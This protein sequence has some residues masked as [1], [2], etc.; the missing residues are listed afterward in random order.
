MKR[1][2]QITKLDPKFVNQKLQEFFKEDEISEDITTN[3]IQQ[4]NKIVEACFIAK[5]SMIF[6]GKEIII[7]GLQEECKLITI[8]QDGERA[9]NGEIIARL[10]GPVDVI[11]KKERVILNLLQR[12]SGIASTTKKLKNKLQKHGIQLLDTRKTTPGLRQFEKFAVNVGGGTNHRLSLKDAAMIKD[13]HLIG[14]SSLSKTVESVV[15]QNPGK[16]VEVEVD[17]KE[18]LKEALETRATS[19]LLDNF[20]PESLPETINYIRSHKKGLGV[21][22]ELSGGIN[23]SNIDQYNIKG[24][25]GISVGALT[26]NITSKDISLDLK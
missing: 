13:N 11:L 7:Q 22:I 1:H 8:K 17:T 4:E 18:Q 9:E 20:S 21:Y 6:A 16:D 5:E 26:H 3:T 10:E 14:S 24:V 25:D 12:L 23:E 19:I 15:K 2:K